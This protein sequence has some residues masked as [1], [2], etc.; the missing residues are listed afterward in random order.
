MKYYAQTIVQLMKQLYDNGYSK[1]DLERMTVAYQLAMELFTGLYRP[2]GK[3]FISHVV[4]TASILCE[5]HVRGELIAA[6]LLHAAYE[7]G[8]FGTWVKGISPDKRDKLRKTLGGEVE[9]YIA[10]YTSL[11]WTEKTIPEIYKKFRLFSQIERDVLVVR[12]ANELED[13]SELGVLYC[14]SAPAKS[15]HYSRIALPMIDMADEIGFP[16]LA[17]ELNEA[18]V[19]TLAEKAF[20]EL[21]SNYKGVRLLVPS[22]Y[23]KSVRYRIGQ[24]CSRV[25]DHMRVL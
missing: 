16:R 2:S 23:T 14:Y 3:T 25:L 24:W 20:E 10:H 8:D 1:T 22:S 17:E 11:R 15:R 13:L 21:K 4:G 19:N 9:N 18:V 5:L 6:G 12:L 7:Q